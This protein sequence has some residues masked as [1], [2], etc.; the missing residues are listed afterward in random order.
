MRPDPYHANELTERLDCRINDKH[1]AFL[2]Y[3]HDGNNSFSP[4]GIG[5]L[6]SNWD[7]NTN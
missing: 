2:R 4:T 3:S 7:V 5:D 1:N 6:P